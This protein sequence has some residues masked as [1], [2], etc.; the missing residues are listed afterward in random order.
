MVSIGDVKEDISERMMCRIV[1]Q[2][3]ATLNNTTKHQ[4]SSSS[5][6]SIAMESDG[7]TSVVQKKIKDNGNKNNNL[8][9]KHTARSSRNSSPRTV[10]AAA[11]PS[12]KQSAEKIPRKNRQAV[13]VKPPLPPPINSSNVN[14]RVHTTRAA[15]RNAG[16]T[17]SLFRGI[18]DMVVPPKKQ[19][20]KVSLSKS[21][22]D[23]SVVK[24]QMLT[25]VLYLYRDGGKRHAR[26]VRTK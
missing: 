26:F 4:N 18:E 9:G 16:S 22:N 10:H 1:I 7:S 21:K 13:K 6:A 5:K 20:P 11:R 19:Q 15:T 14:N 12:T 23:G 25:G 17:V 8:G 3:D 2:S 24:V